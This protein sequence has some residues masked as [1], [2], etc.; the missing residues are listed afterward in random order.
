[1]RRE[2]RFFKGTEVRVAQSGHIE[3]HAAVFNQNYVLWDS[4]S[5]RVTET[6]R[7]GTFTR[8]LS[9]KEQDPRCLFNHDPNQVLGRQSAGTLTLEQNAKG[10]KFD[11]DMPDTQAGR[12][13]RTSIQRKDI[14]G[15]SFAFTVSKQKRTEEEKDGKLLILREIQEVDNLYDVGPVTYPAYEGTDVGARSLG[16]ELRS[17]FPD[18]IPESVKAHAPELRDDEVDPEDPDDPDNVPD[19]D[20]EDNIEACSCPCRACY[21]AEC[22]ECDMHMQTCGDAMRCNG[23]MSSSRSV[24]L[25]DGTKT[26]RVDGEDL[27]ASAFL[28]VGDP[29][30]TSTWKLPWKFSTD[31]KT[32]SHLRNALARFN[33]TQGIPAGEKKK[34]Y[35]KLVRLAKKYGIHVA[36]EDD[37]EQNSD[38]FALAAAKTAT[39]LAELE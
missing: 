20:A 27:P 35:A 5:L 7:P 29:N 23:D 18:G 14:N 19:G 26:K 30:D 33:Q 37:S 38:G 16:R 24:V 39:L 3:G 15:C 22:N 31:E 6:I 9:D 32:K 21:D 34:V 10:L 25:R 4:P 11:C 28:Y 1:M 13:V 12:D 2:R 36:G 17:I 8:V